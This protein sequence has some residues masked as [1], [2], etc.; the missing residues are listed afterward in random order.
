MLERLKTFN[1]SMDDL[2]RKLLIILIMLCVLGLAFVLFPYVAPFAVASLLAW[3]VDPFVRLLTRLLHR[4]RFARTLAAAVSTL[5]ILIITL[6]LFM[7][8][9]SRAFTEL[10]SL[11]YALPGWAGSVVERLLDWFNALDFQWELLSDTARSYI[12]DAIIS[13][14]KTITSSATSLATLLARGAWTTATVALPQV[15]LFIT[16]SFMG[17]FYLSSDRT[18]VLAFL[19]SL[20][21]NRM[22]KSSS[23]VKQ[24]IFKAILSQVRA[25]L[26]MMFVTFTELIIGF[27]I[28]G[29]NYALLLAIL[30]SLLDALPVIGTGL[31][32]VPFALYG[33]LVGNFRFAIGMAVLYIGIGIVRQTLEPRILGKH[34]GLHPLATMMSMYAGYRFIGVWGMLLGPIV[35]L[36]CKVVVAH[37]TQPREPIALETPADI[38]V[39]ASVTYPVTKRS[40]H[41]ARKK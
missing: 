16:L 2:P 22:V 15:V 29:M 12:Q 18:K 28:L 17:T 23:L 10:K 30:I 36:I 35:L 25:Q 13:L 20:I 11:A 14:G 37:V 9:S 41:R 1:Q 3:M 4:V 24:S 19:H 21:P 6:L 7:M 31:F 26:I 34:M 8:L 39:P 40:T 27:S 33:L 32:L 5:M 38:P